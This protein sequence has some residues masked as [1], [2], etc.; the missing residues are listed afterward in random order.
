MRAMIP[1]QQRPGGYVSSD[2]CRACHPDQYATWHGSYHRTMTQEARPDTVIGGFDNVRLTSRGL[3]ARLFRVGDGFWANLVDPVWKR[4]TL[5]QG[6]NPAA[7]QNPPRVD[8]RIVMTTGSHN[9]QF[10]WRRS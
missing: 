1:H 4:Q 8:R 7:A 5:A 10:D 3:E 6:D 9:M 2:K